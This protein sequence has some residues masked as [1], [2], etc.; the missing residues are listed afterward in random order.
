[1]KVLNY[2]ASNILEFRA[3]YPIKNM[4]IKRDKLVTS[5]RQIYR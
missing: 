5:W 2:E 4:I 3:L 1:L